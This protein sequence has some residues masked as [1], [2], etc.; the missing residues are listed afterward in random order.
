L[1]PAIRDRETVSTKDAAA[2]LGLSKVTV[3]EKFYDGLISGYR[4]TE[5]KTGAILVYLD[6]VYE[7]AEKYQG[8]SI[9]PKKK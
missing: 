5:G 3:I 7:Y 2:L 6:S 9:R 1:L 8:R 4:K